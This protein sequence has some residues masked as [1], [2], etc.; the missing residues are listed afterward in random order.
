MVNPPD[1]KKQTAAPRI[2][3]RPSDGVMEA[4]NAAGKLVAHFNPRTN[5]TRDTQGVL[6]GKGNRL[7]AAL[8]AKGAA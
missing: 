4:R 3:T 5:E 7:V 1:P 2:V 8:K 6:I